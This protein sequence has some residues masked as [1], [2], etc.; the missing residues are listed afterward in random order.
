MYCHAPVNIN[1][2]Y[3]CRKYK[4]N[5]LSKVAYDVNNKV[6]LLCYTL[7]EEETNSN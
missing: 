1:E 2:I 7:V 4:T 3:L 5:L 6:F